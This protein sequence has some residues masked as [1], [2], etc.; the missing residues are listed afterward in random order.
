[1]HFVRLIMVSTKVSIQRVLKAITEKN[2]SGHC[3]INTNKMGEEKNMSFEWKEFRRN[4]CG[5]L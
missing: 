3:L 4:F 5:H 2:I 1:M